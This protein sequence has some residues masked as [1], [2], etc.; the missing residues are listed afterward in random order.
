[1]PNRPLALVEYAQAATKNGANT[2]RKPLLRQAVAVLGEARGGLIRA[3]PLITKC[4]KYDPDLVSLIKS[5]CKPHGARYNVQ[6]KI[7]NV[8]RWAART[9]RQILEEKARTMEITMGLRSN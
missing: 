5:V 6:Y 1:M 7:W 4:V 2:A 8:P 3:W 9:V